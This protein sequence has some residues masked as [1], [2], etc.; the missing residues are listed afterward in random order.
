MGVCRKKY[1]Y[2]YYNRHLVKYKEWENDVGKYI[3]NTF[4]PDSILDL[5][6]G[7]GSYIEGAL[8][9]G[10]KKVLGIELNF[11]NAKEYFTDLICPYIISGDV[12]INLKLQCKFD[13]VISFEVGEHIEPDGTQGFINNLTSYTN[14]YIIFTAASPGQRGTGHINLLDKNIWIESVVKK[15]FVYRGDLVDKCKIDWKEFNV[16]SYIIKNLMIF[17]KDI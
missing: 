12:T 17:R 14:K 9:A 6:C 7:V 10:C 15:G 3:F 2:K 13:C 5:G 16:E 11:D 1:S 4:S 8:L